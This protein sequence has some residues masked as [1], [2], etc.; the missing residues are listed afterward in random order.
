MQAYSGLLNA[1]WTDAERIGY[2]QAASFE[3]LASI[4]LRILRRMPPPVGQVCGPISTG[5]VG[6]IEGNVRIFREA[7]AE[8]ERNGLNIFNQMPFESKL[9]EIKDRE[10]EGDIA[11][12]EKFYRPIFE[13][14][15]VRKLYFIPGWETS[16]GATWEHTTGGLLGIERIYLRQDILRERRA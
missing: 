9:I 3:H 2:E 11:I 4:G 14:G 7:I 6:T 15:I 1:W 5:G 13:S 8:L 10:P 16:F 12:L